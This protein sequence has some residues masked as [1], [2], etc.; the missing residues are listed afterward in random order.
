MRKNEAGKMR[1]RSESI[2]NQRPHERRWYLISR[3]ECGVAVFEGEGY[4]GFWKERDNGR[5]NVILDRKGR[6][7]WECVR[8]SSKRGDVISSFLGRR[9]RDTNLVKGV[10]TTTQKG[11]SSLRFVSTM[12]RVIR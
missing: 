5:E 3:Q 1:H 11:R 4:D 9:L 12:S 10:S 6:E 7:V 8:D 2:E